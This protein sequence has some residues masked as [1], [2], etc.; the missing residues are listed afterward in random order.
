M[1]TPHGIQ[2]CLTSEEMVKHAYDCVLLER[3]WTIDSITSTEFCR[4]WILKVLL[5]L[6]MYH[7]ESIKY[8]GKV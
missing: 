1:N 3:Y 7:P 6:S 8:A 4:H 5:Q 2:T